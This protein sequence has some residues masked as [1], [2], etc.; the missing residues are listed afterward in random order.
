[1]STMQNYLLSRSPC[2]DQG[3]SD[4]PSAGN[5]RHRGRV[6]DKKITVRTVMEELDSEVVFLSFESD[7]HIYDGERCIF[8]NVNVYDEGMYGPDLCVP[9]EPLLFSTETP[10]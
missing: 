1:M 5:I 9:R 3:C 8:C 6:L 2:G 4:K 10:K 7:P